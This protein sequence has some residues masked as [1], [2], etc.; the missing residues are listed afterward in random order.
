MHGPCCGGSSP[1]SL[2][3]ARLGYISDISDM[4]LYLISASC[5]HFTRALR[6]KSLCAELLGEMLFAFI[7]HLCLISFR[8]WGWYGDSFSDQVGAHSPAIGQKGHWGCP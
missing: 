4:F 1:C 8:G 7:L 2:G 3:E 6:N 5:F